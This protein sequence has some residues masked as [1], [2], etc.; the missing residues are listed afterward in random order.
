[1]PAVVAAMDGDWL[2]L[3]HARHLEERGLP[4]VFSWESV[5]PELYSGRFLS[6]GLVPPR[7]GVGPYVAFRHECAAQIV[8]KP[9]VVELPGR[10][11]SLS[12][13]AARG[14]GHTKPNRPA[15]AARAETSD[16]ARGPSA[17]NTA[18]VAGTAPGPQLDRFHS[19]LQ[20]QGDLEQGEGEGEDTVE[21]VQHSRETSRSM[22]TDSSSSDVP[23]ND[24]SSRPTTIDSPGS[25]N[26]SMDGHSS[27]ASASR[28]GFRAVNLPGDQP[29]RAIVDRTLL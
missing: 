9:P 10:T 2:Q 28:A 13:P 8:C 4:G 12:L 22:S 29:Q 23:R 19:H 20:G 15:E 11:S 5:R 27:G 26:V 24:R 17:L 21:A 6:A 1:M 25:G 7:S 18:A 16:Q 3:W 14:T